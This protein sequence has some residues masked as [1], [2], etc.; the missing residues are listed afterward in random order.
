MADVRP[1]ITTRV[2][3]A[4]PPIRT[5]FLH[6]V[7]ERFLFLQVP[8]SVLVTAGPPGSAPGRRVY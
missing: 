1:A 2:C 3:L 7:S 4:A 6:D 5:V 8:S